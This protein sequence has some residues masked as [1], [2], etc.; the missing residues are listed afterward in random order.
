MTISAGVAER[1]ILRGEGYQGIQKKKIRR[2]GDGARGNDAIGMRKEDG[3]R[4]RKRRI[5]NQGFYQEES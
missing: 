4:E 1:R 5:V 2:S 3:A